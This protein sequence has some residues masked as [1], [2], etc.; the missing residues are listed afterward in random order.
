MGAVFMTPYLICGQS[1]SKISRSLGRQLAA[2]QARSIFFSRLAAMT[3]SCRSCWSS[4]RRCSGTGRESHHPDEAEV[5][6]SRSARLVMMR[7]PLEYSCSP[8]RTPWCNQVEGRGAGDEQRLV[9]DGALGGHG[10]DLLGV[11]VVVEL[12]R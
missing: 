2:Y 4:S 3:F 7:T 6:G 11:S 1:S 8:S 9:G 12:V 10:D 5:L